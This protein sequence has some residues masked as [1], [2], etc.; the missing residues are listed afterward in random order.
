MDALY[1]LDP[2]DTNQQ[3]KRDE[4]KKLAVICLHGCRR[5][6]T[7]PLQAVHHHQTRHHHLEDEGVGQDGAG[8]VGVLLLL[9]LVLLLQL[10]V[11]LA[12]RVE[13]AGV[14]LR[15]QVEQHQVEIL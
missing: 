3:K 15:R 13:G 11:L 14:R 8:G 7:S 12:G 1:C 10:L 6:R 5:I 2:A 4:N 9:L